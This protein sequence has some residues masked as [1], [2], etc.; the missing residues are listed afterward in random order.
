MDSHISSLVSLS[1]SEVEFYLKKEKNP[2]K[3]SIQM[4]YQ[5]EDF[6]LIINIFLLSPCSSHPI[7]I[8][9]MTQGF[10]VLATH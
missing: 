3:I 6:V 1:I 7:T 8:C 2:K 4:P 5:D 9:A 10:S